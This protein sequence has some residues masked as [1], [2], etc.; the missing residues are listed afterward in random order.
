MQCALAALHWMSMGHGYE[1]TGLDAHEAHRLALD[2]AEA[3]HQPEL[4]LVT[5]EQALGPDR[6][7]SA[8]LRRVLG[9]PSAA[10][11]KKGP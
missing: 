7:M 5:I 1:L 4:A 6:P 3:C 10:A 9:L 8:W 2:G 11:D